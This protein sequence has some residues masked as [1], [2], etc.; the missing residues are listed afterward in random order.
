MAILPYSPRL[1]GSYIGATHVTSS[2]RLRSYLLLGVDVYSSFR[3][4]SR[5]RRPA[6]SGV[7]F[8]S[9]DKN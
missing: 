2:M 3:A 1:A 7:A 6:L 5:E 8:I 9:S 4:V